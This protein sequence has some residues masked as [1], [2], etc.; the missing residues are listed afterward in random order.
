MDDGLQG[1]NRKTFVANA[2]ARL[3]DAE[4]RRR[5]KGLAPKLRKTPKLQRYERQVLEMMKA[6]R[7]VFHRQKSAGQRTA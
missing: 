6:Q 2:I 3:W 5:S 4:A 1:V 7:V